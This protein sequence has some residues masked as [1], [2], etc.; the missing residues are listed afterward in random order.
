M[1][2]IY[3]KARTAVAQLRC[4][5]CGKLWTSALYSPRKWGDEVNACRPAFALGWRIFAAA[6][7]RRTYCPDD[8]PTVPMLPIY[9]ER[10]K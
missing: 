5:K 7:G 4:D 6:R 2:G 8:E 10:L 3:E 1:S 9:P